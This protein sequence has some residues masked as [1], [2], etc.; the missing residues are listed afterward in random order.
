[1]R[2]NDMNGA[3]GTIRTSNPQSLR[4]GPYLFANRESWRD[5]IARSGSNEAIQLSVEFQWIA[6]LRSQ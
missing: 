1:M 3:P 5:V 2:T 4:L 6:S